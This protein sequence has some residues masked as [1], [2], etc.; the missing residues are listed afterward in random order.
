[1]PGKLNDIVDDVLTRLTELKTDSGI[2][3]A[4]KTVSRTYKSPLN[5]DND[6]Y[7]ALFIGGSDESFVPGGEGVEFARIGQ[8]EGRMKLEVL[9]YVNN[10][11]TAD[12][13]RTLVW[14]CI[15]KLHGDPLRS[16]KAK[17]TNIFRLEIAQGWDKEHR[18][19]S[20]VRMIFEITY[21]FNKL[22]P[23]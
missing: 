7:P 9:S 19:V 6:E 20:S 12:K 17:D 4:P 21:S 23:A 3:V 11:L 14:D 1:M 5:M 15:K 13:I 10:D 18:D 8:I 2:T 22:K 16:N